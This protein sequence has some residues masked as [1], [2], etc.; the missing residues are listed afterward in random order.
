MRLALTKRNI[1]GASADEEGVG[2]QAASAIIIGLDLTVHVMSD[3]RSLGRVT[4]P[5]HFHLQA[6]MLVSASEG[7]RTCAT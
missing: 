4:M 5:L 3:H 1:R 2:G 6:A 7:G